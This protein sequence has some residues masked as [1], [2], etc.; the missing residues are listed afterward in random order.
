MT[1]RYGPICLAVLF[2]LW[3]TGCDSTPV[4]PLPS[5]QETLADSVQLAPGG[6]ISAGGLLLTFVEATDDSRCPVDVTCIWQGTAL[7][8]VV[9]RAGVGA[10]TPEVL[11]PFDRASVDFSGYRVT[12]LGLLPVPREGI[13][14]DPEDYRASFRVESLAGPP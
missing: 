13:A 7:V 1:T 5:A 2:P 4:T 3:G 12:L 9:L 11:N 6:Q 10:G 8:H 14:I